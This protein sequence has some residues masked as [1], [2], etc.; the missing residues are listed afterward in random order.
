VALIGVLLAVV[1]LAVSLSPLLRPV[2]ALPAT[3][4]EPGSGSVRRAALKQ[5]KAA[6]YESLKDLDFELATGKLAKDDYGPA[7]EQLLREA[8]SVV[9]KLDSMG[10]DD[11][12]DRFIE[13]QVRMRSRAAGRAVG[14]AGGSC[15]S[16]GAARRGEASFCHACGARFEPP[17]CPACGREVVAGDRFCA[18]CGGQ[19]VMHA[20]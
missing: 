11:V 18:G 7:R 12:L 5:R 10:G 1:A 16:C 19:L 15:A 4:T 13:E 9:R 20:E 3:G 14:S 17:V 2:E 6:L 8:A